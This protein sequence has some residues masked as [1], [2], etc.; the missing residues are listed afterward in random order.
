M[1]LIMGIGYNGAC[2]GTSRGSRRHRNTGTSGSIDYTKCNEL[3]GYY[4]GS[5]KPIEHWY[6]YFKK[7]DLIF[8]SA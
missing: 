8:Q 7:K 5:P 1:A 4:F 2:S 3:Q 6:K